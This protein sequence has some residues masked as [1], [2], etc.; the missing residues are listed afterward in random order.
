M[1]T[2]LKKA[3]FNALL[4]V[5]N[6]PENIHCNCTGYDVTFDE[7]PNVTQRSSSVVEHPSRQLNGNMRPPYIR[8]S[9]RCNFLGLNETQ[10]P[11]RIASFDAEYYETEHTLFISVDSSRRTIVDGLPFT[12]VL[13]PQW[14]AEIV[15]RHREFLPPQF[16]VL[17]PE[18]SHITADATSRLE[19][20]IQSL[21]AVMSPHVQ[22]LDTNA[23]VLPTGSPIYFGMEAQYDVMARDD[24]VENTR[25]P[26]YKHTI[27]CES[28]DDDKCD[29]C[30][31]EKRSDKR[32]RG[33]ED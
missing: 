19:L 29:S 14:A 2:D 18:A 21:G 30:Q 17:Y 4:L 7:R 12:F 6:N 10:L 31:K 20:R 32:K 23:L 22:L 8:Y 28:S 16:I 1:T 11:I 5:V 13:I 33:R 26:R 3:K 9:S 15:K 27:W 24:A 25:D